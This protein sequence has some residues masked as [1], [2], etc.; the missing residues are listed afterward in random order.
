MSRHL[1]KAAFALLL[2]AFTVLSAGLSRAEDAYLEPEAAFRFSARMLDPETV[3]VSYAI[4]DGYYMY[5]ER[6]KF[7][8]EGAT[9]G[10]PVFPHGKVKFDET[11]QKDVE[12]YRGTVT[13]TLPV[14]AAGMFSL[15]ATSQGCADAGLCYAPQD[16]SARLVGALSGGQS[17]AADPLQVR[18]GQEPAPLV[19]RPGTSP[20]AAAVPPQGAPASA[21]PDTS[22]QGHL[23]SLLGG[24]KLLIIIPAFILLG[25]GLSFTPCVL[26]MVPIL[27]SIIVGSGSTVTRARG[28]TLALAYSLGMALVY[29]A[30]GVAAGLIGEGLSAS[31][32]NPWVLGAIGLMMALMSLSMFGVYELQLPSALQTRLVGASGRMSAGK[33]AGVFA[34]GALSA[35][36]VG[37]CV[38]APLVGA[39]VYIGQT[40]DVLIGGLALFSMAAG[41]SIPLLLVGLSAGTLLPH[42]GAWM[43]QVK[44]FFGVL[45]L[46]VALWLVSP[47]LP[48]LLQMLLWSA[49]LIGYGA[50][51]LRATRHWGGMA[52]AAV[53]AILGAVQLTGAA[54]GGRDVLAP[55]GHF[56][57]QEHGVT[58]K[59]IKTV[60]QL[61]AALAANRGRTAM[62]DFYADWCVSCKEMEKLTFV[63]PGVKRQLA[64]T[65]LLQVDVTANDADDKA[66][67]KRF[68]LFGPPSIILFDRDGREIAGSRVVGYQDAGKFGNSLRK[69]Q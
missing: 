7:R 2:L 13:I 38:A 58:F 31:L 29:T 21:A 4:A 25:L 6:F 3:A 28:F 53:C 60:A 47:V 19:D 34:M 52:L 39:L 23:A 41:M 48:P 54:T 40:R 18:F 5:R 68:G 32:Q 42:A 26:P 11:F 27:A 43:D 9:L 45:M 22:E 36:I 10:E 37:P 14:K 15:V 24:G 65:L 57:P 33:F 12:T 20:A 61:D 62:L 63:D 46:A 64:D 50:Y 55:L 51:L 67:L 66:M 30:L 59:R 16:A 44:K 1:F 49:L 69:L 17:S 8:A 56:G 35:L